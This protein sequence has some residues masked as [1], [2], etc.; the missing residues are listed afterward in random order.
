MDSLL[1]KE[2]FGGTEEIFLGRSRRA[3][4]LLA[5]IIAGLER[6]AEIC[7]FF[8]SHGFRN[9]LPAFGACRAVVVTTVQTGAHIA[10][11]FGAG[12]TT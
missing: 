8:I 12:V 5:V 7:F 9:F 10:A 6:I 11:T 1:F 2:G 3:R 4:G